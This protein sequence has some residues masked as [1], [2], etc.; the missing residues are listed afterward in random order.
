VP[1]FRVSL[2]DFSG[3]LDL[4]LHLVRRAEM[5]IFNL[6]VSRITED[7]LAFIEREGVPD[8]EEAYHFL[9]MAAS[10][11][12]LKS[13]ML[14]PRQHKEPSGEG[15]EELDPREDLSRK[16][17]VF[18]SIQGAVDEL[19]QRYEQAGRHWPRQ[20][21]EQIEEEIVYSIDS[22]SIYDLM[23]SFAEVLA[24]P[25]FS[26]ITIFREDY[27]LE[28]ASVWLHKRL[29]AAPVPL[30]GLLLEHKDSYSL[31]VTFIA[32]LEQIKEGQVAFER[33]GGEIVI[34]LAAPAEVI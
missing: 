25:R 4:I 13:R 2:S 34:S 1:R 14:L 30:T 18:E 33:E 11:V 10:L 17:A 5:D 24:R 3:P 28:E 19:A 7:Y 12:E 21:A 22:L 27:D 31:I 15:G 8:L 32:L 16:L 9:A 26:Q 6:D 29:S 23:T 20:V